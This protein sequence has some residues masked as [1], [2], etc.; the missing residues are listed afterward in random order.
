MGL[1]LRYHYGCQSGISGKMSNWHSLEDLYKLH[2]TEIFRYLLRRVRQKEI[3]QDL[4][5]DTFLKAFNGLA[6]FKGNSSVK[7]WLYTIAHNTFINWY[8]KETKYKQDHLI[9]S[10]LLMRTFI[11]IQPCF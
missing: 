5:Q 3:A 9:I 7:T 10:T 6:T 2:Y 4:T 11:K 8:R 1:L